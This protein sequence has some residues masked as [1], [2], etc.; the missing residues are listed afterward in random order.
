VRAQDSTRV[1]R[2]IDGRLGRRLGQPEAERPL[3]RA[4]LLCLHGAEP[5]HDVGRPAM[6]GS[7]DALV[8]ESQ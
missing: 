4:K 7:R 8:V 5:R 3:R 1:E 2:A 6:A